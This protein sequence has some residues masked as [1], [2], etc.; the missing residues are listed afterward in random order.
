MTTSEEIWKSRLP[1]EMAFWESWLSTKGLIWPET[2]VDA[3]NPERPLQDY[4]RALVDFQQP[5][6]RIL[7]VGS[8]PLTVLGRVWEG[9]EVCTV[10]IDPLADEYTKLLAHHGIT[11]PVPTRLCKGEELLE[12]FEPNTFD[13][14]HAQNSLDHSYDPLRI[15]WN[16]LAV[17]KPGGTVYL[18][19]AVREADTQNHEGL[20]RWNFFE[21]NGDF[22]VEGDDGIVNVSKDMALVADIKVAVPGWIQVVLKTR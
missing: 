19:H 1:S 15:I 13:L 16:M 17:V 7:D 21:D 10:P 18:N 8:G 5:K 3:L 6:V 20:H 2:Y 22:M 11:A 9:H 12:Q 4:L 14:A